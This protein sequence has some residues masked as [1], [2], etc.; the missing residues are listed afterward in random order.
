VDALEGREEKEIN[1]SRKNQ[2]NNEGAMGIQ[3]ENGSRG[4]YEGKL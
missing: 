3:L 2:V 1:N 4:K